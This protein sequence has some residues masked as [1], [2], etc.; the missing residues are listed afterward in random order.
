LVKG[1]ETGRFAGTEYVQAEGTTDWQ[2]LD[3]VLKQGYRTTPPPLPPIAVRRGA[4]PALIW[5]G[6]AGG[7]IFCLSVV[8][9]M[10]Y[11]AVRFQRD[12]S[13]ISRVSPSSPLNEL[14]PAAVATA[15]KP[16]V[17]DHNT[18]TVADDQKRN[19][20]FRLRLWVDGY[21]QHGARNP[22]CD[23]E[24]DLFLR[25]YIARNYAG[26]EA[27]NS[28]SLADESDKLG[29]DTNC[30]DA[31]VLTVAADEALNH[32]DA[33]RLFRRALAAYP[34]SSHQA[35][36]QFYATVRLA[37]LLGYNSDQGGALETSALELVKRCFSDGSFTPDDQ[38]EIAD[39]FINQWGYDFFQ[40][41]GA[42]IC[43]I[44]H[45]AG[46]KYQWLTSTLNG[47]HEIN[48]AWVA[49]GDGGANSVTDDGWKGFRAHLGAA[50][51]DLTAAWTLQPDWAVAPDLMMTVSLGD[52]D[53]SEMRM[54]FDRTTKAQIDYAP[55][56]KEMRWGLRPRW[57]GN[58][59]AMLALGVAAIDTG[60]F[61][62]D[63]PRK[64]LDCVYDVESEMGLASGKHI[65]GRDDIWPNLARMYDGYV[66]ASSQKEYL[67][68]WR[69]SYAVAAYFAGKYDVARAQL[70]ALD[71]KPETSNLSDW[72]VDL[73]LMPLEV[74]ART[75]P[76]GRK[77]SAAERARNFGDFSRAMKEYAALKD[78]P[79]AD[80]RTRQ[81]IE[82]RLS[83]LNAE[84]HL[85][86]GD[87]VSLLPTRDDDSNWIFSF[88]KVHVLPDGAVEVESGPKGHMLFSRLRAGMNFEVRGQFEVVRS[89]NKN[90]QG[91][92]V[93]GVPNFD[94]WEWYGFRL[95]RHVGEEGDVACFAVGWSR[96]QIAQ[97]IV[98]NDVTNSFDMTF[99][100]SKVT[101]S[102]NGVSVFDQADP[103]RQISVP[104]NSCL[105]GLGAFNDSSDTVIRYRKVQLRKL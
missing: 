94:G 89:A 39:I 11:M 88:G 7:V 80:D 84:K 75:G 69:T 41:N 55:A 21:E 32:F 60:R 105:I 6:I 51:G 20:A 96:E 44:S 25:T 37:G 40:Q 78:A 74:A 43:S 17:W 95:K 102:V 93:M 4:P 59:K 62:T 56:W 104:G 38:Q 64:Y 30:T 42:S 10:G 82:C 70:E 49:R 99:Q 8:I 63:V 48:E 68:G 47:E 26:K 1:R 16:I 15:G 33:I 103:P 98:L 66:S 5:T 45:D 58:E 14:N 100:D 57:Y 54:W 50:R 71:W 73:S 2:P 22:E 12:I 97:H 34:S 101:A 91:G 81:F 67:N 3:L 52:S 92:V 36:P 90:F 85:N 27:T 76:I 28:M 24:A 18:Q 35:Y 9:G 83:E 29:A 86:D 87:W 79:D 46:P 61:D 72:N 53:L 77:V 31:V 23:A 19:R 65:F 13:G